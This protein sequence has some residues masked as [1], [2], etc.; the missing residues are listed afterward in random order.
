MTPHVLLEKLKALL[1][2]IP[3]LEGRGQYGNEQYSWLGQANALMHEWDEIKSIPFKAAV[4][5]LL[6]NINRPGNFGTVVAFFH[7]VIARL[8]NSLPQ[9]AGQAFGPGAAYDFFKA[10][11]DLVSTA[12]VQ[13]W[14]VDPYLDAE[15]FDGYMQALHPGVSARLLTAKYL[16]NVRVAAEKYQ[17]QFGSAVEVRSSNDIHDRVIFADNDQ[18]WVLGASIKDAALKK[19]TYLAPVSPDVAVEK[20]KLYEAIWAAGTPI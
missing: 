7:D 3:P 17:A 10:L 18:C 8:E 1:Q 2:S 6:Q 9:D 19:P 20:R 5:G 11:N 15:V 4:N 16:N 12:K 13:L 14:V